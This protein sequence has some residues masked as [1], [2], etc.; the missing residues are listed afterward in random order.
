MFTYLGNAQGRV[1][2]LAGTVL[3]NYTFFTLSFL[4]RFFSLFSN[5]IHTKNVC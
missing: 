2:N 1:Y 4:D 5:V 3:E